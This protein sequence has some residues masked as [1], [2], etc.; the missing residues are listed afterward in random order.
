MPF[1]PLT[2]AIRSSRRNRQFLI[3]GGEA[4]ALNKNTNR[5]VGVFPDLRETRIGHFI[6]VYLLRIRGARRGRLVGVTKA[7]G[8][9]VTYFQRKI[10]IYIICALFRQI[11]GRFITHPAR[12]SMSISF[13]N[14]VRNT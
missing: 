8:P 12:A 2:A 14:V 4:G 1:G 7:S 13:L 3:G 6:R 11:R 9:N 5:L 10:K